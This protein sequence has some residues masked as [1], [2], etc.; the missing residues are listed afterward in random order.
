MVVDGSPPFKGEIS[1][2]GEPVSL[3]GAALQTTLET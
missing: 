1:A 2:S 3:E